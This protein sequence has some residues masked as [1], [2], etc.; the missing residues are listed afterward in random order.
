MDVKELVVVGEE[1][2]GKTTLLYRFHDGS[3]RS[4]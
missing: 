2:I 4:Y 1:E 3:D